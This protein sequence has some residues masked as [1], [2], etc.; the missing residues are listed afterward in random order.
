MPAIS[1]ASGGRSSDNDDGT[2]LS[3]L[4]LAEGARGAYLP[5]SLKH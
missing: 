1:L 4:T 2:F 3:F 5:L